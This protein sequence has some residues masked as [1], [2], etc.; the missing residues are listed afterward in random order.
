MIQHAG[1]EQRVAHHEQPDE[2]DQQVPIHLA[3][4]VARRGPPAQQQEA[5]RGERR[6]LAWHRYEK[7]DGD[8]RR[9]NRDALGRLPAIEGEAA[10]LGPRERDGALPAAAESPRDDGPHD[11]QAEQRGHQGVEHVA[12]ER[13]VERLADQHVLGVADQGR[14]G[15]DVGRRRQRQQEGNRIEPPPSASRRQNGGHGETY[16][17]VGEQGAEETGDAHDE[18]QEQR[19]GTLVLGEP[20]PDSRV[21]AA[22]PELRRHDHQAEQQCD[23]WNVHGIPGL[24][25]GHPPGR[26]QRDGAEQRHA[27]AIE[28]EAGELAEQHPGVHGGEDDQD[29]RVHRGTRYLV[30]RQQP[31]LAEDAPGWYCLVHS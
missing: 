8:E 25:D 22:E 2:Q 16:D 10:L 27:G 29:R 31:S 26:H 28:G 19:R 6:R 9:Q 12:V 13:E 1:R 21:E 4:D 11:A 18:G 5:G 23:G 15:A 30:S 7:K 24:A 3:E 20:A 17:V 14:R